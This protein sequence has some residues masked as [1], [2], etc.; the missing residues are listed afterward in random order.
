MISVWTTLVTEAYA[1]YTLFDMNEHIF[2]IRTEVT[3]ED[4]VAAASSGDNIQ[5]VMRLYFEGEYSNGKSIVVWFFLK[6]QPEIN[7]GAKITFSYDSYNKKCE[8]KEFMKNLNSGIIQLDLSKD[9]LATINGLNA[10]FP[11][12]GYFQGWKDD[13]VQNIKAY[14]LFVYYSKSEIKDAF[15]IQYRGI[16]KGWFT[17]NS[18]IKLE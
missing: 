6:P 17:H 8:E 13:V 12:C 3:D 16:N 10:D 1:E 7:R 9:H 2:E 15:D 4:V 5:M 18:G 11:S 14:K